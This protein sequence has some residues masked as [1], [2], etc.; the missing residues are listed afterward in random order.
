MDWKVFREHFDKELNKYLTDKI[1]ES[2]QYII[3]DELH[4]IYNFL[5]PY[6]AW[7]K[8]IR[9]YLVYL[10]YKINWWTDDSVA[11]QAWMVNELIHLFALIHDDINDKWTMRHQLPAFHIFAAQ[12]LNDAY[13]WINMWILIWDILISWAYQLLHSINLPSM[14]KSFY[15][16]MLNTTMYGQIQDVYLSHTSTLYNKETIAK[17]DKAKS[18]N[19][20]IM[21]PMVIW[22]SMQETDT[23]EPIQQLG[24]RLGLV[25]QMRDDLLDIIDGH[26]N[27][28][29]FSD[30]QEGNQTFLL[31][32]AF[33]L[34]TPIQKEYLLATRWKPCNEET[35]S[36]LLDIYTTTG[37]ISRAKEQI[38]QELAICT[39]QFQQ[40]VQR[41]PTLNTKYAHYLEHIISF[42][43]ID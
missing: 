5:L 40:R 3:S 27:K 41:T 36:K 35:K 16:Q 11:L 22:R 25:F 8:R 2:E 6:S 28:T 10:M 20:S 23:I 17:K 14:T 43:A 38:N 9:P 32:H 30:H 21:R 1:A 18:W 33:D 4:N 31:A 13:Q 24:E 12:Q 42:L 29:A 19:Y 37:T 34:A 26:G 7:G 15:Y 39:Q